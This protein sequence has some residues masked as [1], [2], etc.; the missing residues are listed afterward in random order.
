VVTYASPFQNVD[1]TATFTG[2]GGEVVKAAATYL[3][4]VTAQAGKRFARLAATE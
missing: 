3:A 1:G 2:P 4:R